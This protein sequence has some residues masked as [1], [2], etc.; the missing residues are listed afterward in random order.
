LDRADAML[1]KA[2]AAFARAE[3]CFSMKQAPRD[4]VPRSLALFR[5][6]RLVG[7][8]AEHCIGVRRSPFQAHAWVEFEG[9]VVHDLPSRQLKYT[10]LARIARWTDLQGSCGLRVR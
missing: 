2:L 5:F 4:C 3:N 1:A 6:L 10:T 8:P 7:L 9:R